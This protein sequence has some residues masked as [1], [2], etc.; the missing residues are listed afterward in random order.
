MTAGQGTLPRT[1]PAGPGVQRPPNGLRG[2]A[3]D[4]ATGGRFAL[5]GGREG[6]TRTLLTA[7]GVGLGVA[8]LLLATAVPGMVRLRDDKSAARSTLTGQY[9]AHPGRDTLLVAGADTTYH[10]RDVTGVLT[11]PEGPDTPLPPGVDRFPGTGEMVV[12]PALRRLLA[13]TPLLRQR[14]PYKDVGTIGQAGL[15][16]PSELYYYAGS[17]QLTPRDAHYRNGNADRISRFGARRYTGRV[18]G[19][20]F[21]LLLVIVLV[22][23]LMP[24]GV[25]VTTSARLGGERRD[26]RLAALRLL[27]ADRLTVLRTAAGEALA[28]ALLGLL[29]GAAF[30]LVGRQLAAHV[31]LREVSAFPSDLRPGTGLTVLVALAVP[32][33]AIAVTMASLRATAIEPLG[34]VRGAPTRRRRL[35]WRLLTPALGLALLVPLFG[36]A[37]GS[38]S[39]NQYQVAAG[40]VLLLLGVTAVLPWLVEVLVGRLHGGPVAW[41]LAVRRLQ[42][43]SGLSARTVSGVTVA[44]AGAIALQMLFQ[45]VSWEFSDPTGADPDRAQ[46]LVLTPGSG[47]ESLRRDTAMLSATP[48]VTGVHGYVRGQATQPDAASYRHDTENLVSVPFEVGDCPTLRELAGITSCRSGSVFLVRQDG[49]MGDP[50]ETAPYLK[51]GARLDL[52]VPEGSAYTG[53][54]RLWTIP[55]GT[56]TVPGRVSPVGD[57]EWGV[58]A[59]PEAVDTAWLTDTATQVMVNIDPHRTDAIEYVRNTA[60]RTGVGTETLTL[61]SSTENPEFTQLRHGLFA[62]AALTMALIG[63]SLL[64]SV[65]EQLRER[66]RL[67]AVLVAFG[68]KRSVLA[69]SVLWQTAVP[70]VL[71]LALASVG[72]VGIGLAL[73]RTAGRPLTVHWAVVAEM[74][75]VGGAVVLAVTLLSLP[76]LWRLMRADGLRTE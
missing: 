64:V 12:S 9:I 31:S 59:T 25:F 43:A 15:I 32:A 1:G 44:V 47:V 23:L 17:D 40:T 29:L 69:W 4:L 30:F 28:G 39:I 20:T 14:L 2:W 16:G 46:V 42:L 54:P 27:G 22:A 11:H 75:G 41:Q 21:D 57:H 70:V 24:V 66:R 8:M 74:A 34:V 5:S 35:W 18:T 71:G 63:A 26:R 6:W 58:L 68:T 52:N 13:G 45:G 36:K 73:L 33:A 50:A 56:P 51:A 10:G 72:G 60:A 76:V 38:G 3:R 7:V 19:P 53:S 67:L 65:L 55:V 62:G 48:G 37:K 61:T 49:T